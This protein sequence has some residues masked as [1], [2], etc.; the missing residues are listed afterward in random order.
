MRQ[1]HKQLAQAILVAAQREFKRDVRLFERHAGLMQL[2]GGGMV[3][4]FHDGQADLYGWM[5][6][7]GVALHVEIE[8]KVGRDELR[9]DQRAWRVVCVDGGVKYAL[10]ECKEV[11]E[12]VEK[13][14]AFLRGVHNGD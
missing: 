7:H 10:V 9:D 11:T 6:V 13:A 3:K 4:P 1:R 5:T 8:L 14:L 12:G 2:L